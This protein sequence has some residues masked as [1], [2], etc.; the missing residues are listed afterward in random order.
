MFCPSCGTRHRSGVTEC[1]RCHVPLVEHEIEPGPESG[2]LDLVT[3]LATG[4]PALVALARSLLES[5]HVPFMTRGEGVQDLVG[6]GRIGAGFNVALGP[7]EF[8]VKAE[9]ADEA[10]EL[11]ADLKEIDDEGEP[12]AGDDEPP[13]DR[14]EG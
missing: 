13:E 11:L 10:L 3:V 8:C 14:G 7:V 2:E 4:D 9:D 12:L 5:A 6:L 1:P